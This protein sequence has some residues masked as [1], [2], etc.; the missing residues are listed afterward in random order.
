MAR[1][2]VDV[3]WP[4][5]ARLLSTHTM[6]YAASATTCSH[7]SCDVNRAQSHDVGHGFGVPSPSM[8]PRKSRSEFAHRAGLRVQSYPRF[9]EQLGT[10]LLVSFFSERCRFPSALSS[11]ASSSASSQPRL[12]IGPGR[13]LWASASSQYLGINV[14]D[15]DRIAEFLNANPFVL[16]CILHTGRRVG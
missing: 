13:F 3:F 7:K 8:H 14:Q 6:S 5:Q 4:E 9:A 10:V 15:L 11:S 1:K 12:Q 16:E 2:D